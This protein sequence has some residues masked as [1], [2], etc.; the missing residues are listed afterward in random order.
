MNFRKFIESAWGGELKY[1]LP[2]N[3]EK[4]LYDFYMLSLFTKSD[5]KE[6]NYV[7]DE[8]Y[9]KILPKLKKE[10]SSALIFSICSEIRHIYDRHDTP[11]L[12]KQLTSIIENNLGKS[13]KEIFI[14]YTKNYLKDKQLNPLAKTFERKKERFN[15]SSDLEGSGNSGNDYKRSYK[16]MLKTT[17]DLRKIV[18][19]CDFLFENSRWNLSY[20][21]SAWSGICKGWHRLENSKS[22]N[23]LIVSIDHVYDLQHN[24][25]TVFNKLQNYY[26]GG[27][28]WI[29]RALDFKRDIKNPFALYE[30][31]SDNLKPIAA[32]VLKNNFNFTKQ[33]YDK[34]KEP[35]KYISPD[36]TSSNKVLPDETLDPLK[37]YNYSRLLKNLNQ[38][39]FIHNFYKKIIDE[40]INKK[41][42]DK[43]IKPVEVSLQDF[44]NYKDDIYWEDLVK[45][46]ISRFNTPVYEIQNK[47]D[48]LINLLDSNKIIPTSKA[49]KELYNLRKYFVQIDYIQGFHWEPGSDSDFFYIYRSPLLKIMQYS[50]IISFSFEP[51][52][53]NVIKMNNKSGVNNKPAVN[54][55][56]DN[57]FNLIPIQ[58]IERFLKSIV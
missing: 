39:D 34:S 45:Q 50:I 57:S 35:N 8:I 2:E 20:G 19:L 7:I 44:I 28:E 29:K 15:Y 41:F 9:E 31:I 22:K 5:N 17:D 24:T 26:I 33:D 55:I 4:M 1:D 47:F 53:I 49:M 58:E 51:D 48:N 30:K 18:N 14:K 46:Y 13:Y 42:I 12:L 56:L 16:A 27:F 25:N 32:R 36:E 54:Y 10:L 11:E 3:K 37:K 40:P 43:P 23:D 21:G 52:Q 6:L 38:P